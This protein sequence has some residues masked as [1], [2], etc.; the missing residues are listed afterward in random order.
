MGIWNYG[1]FENDA[2]CDVLGNLIRELE[3]V[4]EEG[5][6]ITKVTKGQKRFRARLCK[7][8]SNDLECPII[9]VVAVLNSIVSKIS[10]AR[11]C[12]DKERVVK[13]K[14]EY[15]AWFD[16]KCDVPEAREYR[17]N[18]QREFNSLIRKLNAE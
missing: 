9:P 16:D 3:D 7:D 8:F 1:I 11:H 4:V 17:R 13:W 14:H 6:R 18:A 12:L 5:F 2:A 10:Y 15:L